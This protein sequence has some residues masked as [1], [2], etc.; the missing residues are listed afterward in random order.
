MLCQEIK[1]WVVSEARFWYYGQE[2]IQQETWTWSILSNSISMNINCPKIF[3]LFRTTFDYWI[4]LNICSSLRW[5]LCLTL[6][7]TELGFLQFCMRPSLKKNKTLCKQS[8]C[9][10]HS[11]NKCMNDIN[12]RFNLFCKCKSDKRKYWSGC[13]KSFQIKK[14]QFPTPLK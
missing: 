14:N 6:F 10:H 8:N 3:H 2:K 13:Q 12:L 7:P 9:N 5:H 11:S 4:V 1:F